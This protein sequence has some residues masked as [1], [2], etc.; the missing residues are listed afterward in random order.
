MV[1][2]RTFDPKLVDRPLFSEAQSRKHPSGIGS[3]A[4]M[5]KKRRSGRLS[6]CPRARV[7][8]SNVSNSTGASLYGAQYICSMSSAIRFGSEAF[9]PK[10][11]SR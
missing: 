2:C 7:Y 4:W 5:K 1:P 8:L 10:S 11:S 6:A 9:N 3:L